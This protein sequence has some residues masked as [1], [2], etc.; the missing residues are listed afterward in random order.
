[1]DMLVYFLIL[2]CGLLLGLVMHPLLRL[3]DLAAVNS[4]LDELG[5]L[6]C[7][8]FRRLVQ[9]MHRKE[10]ISKAE[11]NETEEIIKNT[12][13]RE[14][15][16]HDSAQ[17]IRSILLTLATAIQRTEKADSDSSQ[18]L[19]D[20]KG[21][22]DRMQLPPDLKEAHT[23]LMQ[24]IDRVV[25]SN[26]HLKTELASSQGILA[27]QRKQIEN[28][29]TAVRI[30]SLTQLAN[31]S[32]FDEK[33]A[34]MIKVTQRYNEPFSLMMIDVDNFKTI[35]DTYGHLA[36]DRILKGVSYKIKESLRSS[37]FL[38][39]Y[40]GDEFALILIKTSSK[41]A[42]YVAWKLC[43]SVR[44]SRFVL[45]GTPLNVTLSI[46][47]AEAHAHDTEESLLKRAD[48]ALYRVKEVGRN[49]VMLEEGD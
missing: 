24:E 27:E 14:Q 13:P 17:T 39:R 46:G 43:M 36:G 7:L 18:T 8:P 33:L 12:D 2:G 48:K 5:R 6:V 40:G 30:D 19:S 49:S 44:E 25:S 45:D 4:F 26:S 31:R 28:L 15:E 29:Q 10:E 41:P 42:V 20:V 47:V 38:A 35:N 37:D 11:L 3:I 9:Y 21:V 16:I 1:M 23:I 32:Y 22:I 34:E